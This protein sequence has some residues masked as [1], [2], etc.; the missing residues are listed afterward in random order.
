MELTDG[1]KI[2]ILLKCYGMKTSDLAALLSCSRQL[3]NYYLTSKDLSQEVKD[4]L[5]TGTGG[6]FDVDA[7]QWKK[8]ERLLKTFPTLSK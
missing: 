2:E 6:A 7:P 5:K 4:K 8:I 1:K 3:V